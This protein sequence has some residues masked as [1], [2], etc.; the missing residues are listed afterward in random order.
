MNRKTMMFCL[1]SLMIFSILFADS[2]KKTVNNPDLYKPGKLTVATGEP[3][4]PP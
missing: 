4:Y 2:H 3:V 1:V